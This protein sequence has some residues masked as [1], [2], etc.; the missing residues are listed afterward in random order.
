MNKN[1]TIDP[2]VQFPNPLYFDY[3]HHLIHCRTCV[4]ELQG[5]TCLG[6]AGT[7][8]RQWRSFCTSNHGRSTGRMRVSS[9]SRNVY[10]NTARIHKHLFE[11]V[12]RPKS[13]ASGRTRV[14]LMLHQMLRRRSK[15]AE[16]LFILQAI[17]I[18]K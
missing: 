12:C 17:N 6:H 13:C 3:L 18:C 4:S 1:T 14:E 9:L 8:A 7:P 5:P 11:V 2:S 16:L 15:L 10:F